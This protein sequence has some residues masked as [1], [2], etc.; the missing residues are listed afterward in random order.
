MLPPLLF[1]T[2]QREGCQLGNTAFPSFAAGPDGILRNL[3]NSQRDCKSDLLL[4]FLHASRAK[5]NTEQFWKP[6]LPSKQKAKWLKQLE[7]FYSKCFSNKQ[8][9][10]CQKCFQW[11]YVLTYIETNTTLF[12]LICFV[13]SKSV[14]HNKS[15]NKVQKETRN[16]LLNNVFRTKQNDKKNLET[17]CL[18]VW[19]P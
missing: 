14:F 12:K 16:Q 3:F 17:D 4:Q 2:W 15:G 9:G 13:F 11:K 1:S 10:L 5:G 18:T 19:I 8:E 6:I 7:R